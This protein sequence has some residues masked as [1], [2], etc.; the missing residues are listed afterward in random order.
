MLHKKGFGLEHVISTTFG[1][2]SLR[3]F[4]DPEAVEPLLLSWFLDSDPVQPARHGVA[5]GTTGLPPSCLGG[6]IG[7]FSAWVGRGLSITGMAG[8]G[9][10]ISGRSSSRES[11][12]WLSSY[13]NEGSSCKGSASAVWLSEASD[14]PE[15]RIGSHSWLKKKAHAWIQMVNIG[16]YILWFQ[17]H[18]NNL[19]IR[20]SIICYSCSFV[21]NQFLYNTSLLP[22]EAGLGE[23][24]FAKGSAWLE[25]L[26]LQVLHPRNEK[27]THDI[28]HRSHW[29]R[30]KADVNHSG[31]NG[32]RGPGVSIKCA[33]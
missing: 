10:G 18:P 5:T 28:C 14:H 11:I 13:S 33:C 30:A 32:C 24:V 16:L 27:V 1:P 22:S 25:H 19:P 17:P 15:L 26:E 23:M 20:W 4:C 12:R 29:I 9:R 31:S 2:Q 3:A 7:T 6:S 21:C 8:G